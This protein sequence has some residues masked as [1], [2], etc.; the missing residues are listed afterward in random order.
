MSREA[1]EPTIGKQP[2][3]ESTYNLP[4]RQD[5]TCRTGSE[6]RFAAGKFALAPKWRIS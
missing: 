5:S 4:K 2:L 6:T 1:D 3:P